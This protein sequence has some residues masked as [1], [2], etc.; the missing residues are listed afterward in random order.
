MTPSRLERS[1]KLAE[2]AR[3]G[4]RFWTLCGEPAGTN[5][6]S[7]GERVHSVGWERERRGWRVRSGWERFTWNTASVESGKMG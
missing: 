2:M 5:R 1:T 4:A 7:P 3:E 6:S